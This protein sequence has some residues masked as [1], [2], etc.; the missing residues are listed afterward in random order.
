[1]V[2]LPLLNI[3]VPTFYFFLLAPVLV[4]LLHI[5]LLLHHQAYQ[6]KLRHWRDGSPK[7]QLDQLAPN[8][9]D[10]AFLAQDRWQRQLV[11]ASLW[12]LLYFWPPV[13]IC[14]AL[15]WF[16]D[17]QNPWVTLEHFILLIVSCCASTYFSRRCNS[18]INKWQ[19]F[20]R[21]IQNF[22]LSAVSLVGVYLFALVILLTW[23][24]EGLNR[25]VFL[26]RSSHGGIFRGRRC[27]FCLLSLTLSYFFVALMPFLRPFLHNRRNTAY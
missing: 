8:F 1:M 25:S 21:W 19:F 7:A 11:R 13:T 5:N 23:V 2:P 22:L 10:I 14:L 12:L 4:V 15:F 20:W 6:D 27:G 16:T 3:S 24:R 18:A 17:Y 26:R 9:F